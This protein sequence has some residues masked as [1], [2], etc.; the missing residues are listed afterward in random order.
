VKSVSFDRYPASATHP[1][2]AGL[3]IRTSEI[4]RQL[5]LEQTTLDQSGKEYDIN[6]GMLVVENLL[7]AKVS[8]LLQQHDPEELKK[9]T[10]SR[11]VWISQAMFEPILGENAGRFNSIQLYGYEVVHYEEQSEGVTVVVK[12]VATGRYKKYK[13]SYLIACDGGRSETRK[14]E[15]IPW[16]GPGYLQNCLNISFEADLS[17]HIGDRVAYGVVYVSNPEVQGG[18]RLEDRGKK[19]L[20]IVTGVRDR[21]ALDTGTVTL[22]QARRYLYDGAGTDDA[23]HPKIKHYSIWPLCAY[24]AGRLASRGGRVFIAGDAAHLMPPTGGFGGNTG[25]AVIAPSDLSMAFY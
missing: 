25:I 3:N 5:D 9:F 17:R 11:W 13:T 2:A 24:N 19:G 7:G 20:F 22:E 1:R 12:E 4:L 21:T 6:A 10:P 23:T 16:E 8:G 18:F 15:G 14:K